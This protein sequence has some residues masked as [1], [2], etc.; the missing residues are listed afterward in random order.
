MWMHVRLT[1]TKIIMTSF[2][3]NMLIISD[4]FRL[5]KCMETEGKGVAGLSFVDYMNYVNS[6][7]FS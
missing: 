5:E 6:T 7:Q 2:L 3:Q 4:K 1:A